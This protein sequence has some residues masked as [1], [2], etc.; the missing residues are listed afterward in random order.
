VIHSKIVGIGSYL[1]EKIYDNFYFEKIV[2]TSD[3]W[4]VERSGIRE[5]H[6][7]AD[8]EYTSDLAL[9][10]SQ[11]AIANAGLVPQDIDTIILSTTTPDLIFPSTAVILQGKLN[12]VEKCFSFDIQAVCSG[13]V[14]ALDLA[15]S[16]IKTKKSKNVLVV[17]AET[18]SR[19]LDWKDRTTCVLFGDGAGAVVL[20]ATEEENKGIIYSE[21]ASQSNI[22]V[23]RTNGGV[24]VGLDNVFITMQGREVFK[25]AVHKMCGSVNDCV[26]KLGITINDID[27][28]VAHQANQRILDAVESRLGLVDGVF[29]STIEKHGN[30]GSASIPLALHDA[31]KKGKVKNGDLVIFEALGGGLTWGAIA[32]RW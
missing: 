17:S 31:Y 27:L 30:T 1:P 14:Y 4:I 10:A 16:L 25:T 11:E 28:I 12:I 13:F 22:D 32:L 7:V 29:H 6:I 15:D 5:R 2:D 20:Q 23:L 9:K 21:I 3:E 8:G 19:I 26:E 24:S 18:F